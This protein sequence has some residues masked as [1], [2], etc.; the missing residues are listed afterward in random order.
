[1]SELDETTK[2]MS[3]L[4]YKLIEEHESSIGTTLGHR[5]LVASLGH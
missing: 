2:M 1:M 5:A 3:R 4:M